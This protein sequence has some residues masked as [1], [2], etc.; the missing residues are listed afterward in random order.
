MGVD[1]LVVNQVSLFFAAI[2]SYL[3]QQVLEIT[4]ELRNGMR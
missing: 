4:Y 2:A 3:Q 1:S